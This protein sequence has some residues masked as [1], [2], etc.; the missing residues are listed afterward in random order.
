MTETWFSYFAHVKDRLTFNRGFIKGALVVCKLYGHFKYGAAKRRFKRG[1]MR[2]KLAF[3]PQP[4]GPWYNIW[5]VL[6]NTDVQITNNIHSADYVFIF[7]DS[8]KSDVTTRLPEGLTASLING[9]ITDISKTNVSRVF[10][11]V[12]G[13]GLAIDPTSY[14]GKAVEKSDEN[15][16]HDGQIIDCPVTPESIK[17]GY[18]YQKLV[19]SSFTGKTAEDL[20]VATV[21]GDVAA[22][23]HKHKTFEKRFGTEYLST[24][25]REASEVFSN[26]EIANIGKFCAVIG[27]DFGAIDVMRD[28]NDGRIYIV[29]V[30]KTCMPVLSLPFSEQCR[31]LNMIAQVFEKHLSQL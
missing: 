15:G 25:V 11:T 29:D 30:N 17:A 23:F 21:F 10:E 24:E 28:K 22:V 3:F 26:E 31:S 8:T 12:F 9:E 27:L 19:D 7:D 16:T 5:L 14:V 18:C 6:Q 2:P 13:Y 1:T 4:A 20:R